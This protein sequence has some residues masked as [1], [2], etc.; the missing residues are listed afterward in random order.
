MTGVA[1]MK[2]DGRGQKTDKRRKRA[3]VRGQMS[4]KDVKKKKMTDDKLLILTICH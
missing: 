4:K 3:E 1:G 2:T